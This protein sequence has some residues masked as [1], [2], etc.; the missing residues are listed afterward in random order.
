MIDDHALPALITAACAAYGLQQPARVEDLGGGFTT[1]LLL[2]GERALVLRAHPD[3]TDRDRLAAVQQARQ[4]AW[5]AGLPTAPPIPTLGG[6]TFIEH[7]GMIIELEAYLPWT[8][9]MNTSDRLITGFTMLGRL[10]DALRDARLPAAAAIAP[11][12]NH[13]DR[14]HDRDVRAGLERLRAWRDHELTLYA[15]HAEDHLAAVTAHE[16]PSPLPRRL[17]HG[18]F[19]DNNVGFTDTMITALLDF[20]FLGE[21]ERIDDLALPF[22]F[23]LLE[24]G[25]G[26]PTAE[27]RELLRSLADAYDHGTDT[28]LTPTERRMLPVAIARQPAW[29]L[30]VWIRTHDDE[31]AIA[32][33][34]AAAAELPTAQAVL[35]DLSVW[36]DR[37]TR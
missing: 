21:R 4:A 19:W 5:T 20:D 24:P 29:S 15:D 26:L 33:A 8:D 34:R 10:H 9:R 25:R 23:W 3:G 13:L 27:D 36:Q 1:N 7:T 37:L 22:W 17:C 12:A 30:G 32:H 11:Y 2:A 31:P 16:D 35:A 18:D 6:D 14:D 28:P